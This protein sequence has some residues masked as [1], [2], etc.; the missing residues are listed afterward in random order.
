MG[1]RGPLLLLLALGSALAQAPGDGGFRLM[2]PPGLTRLQLPQTTVPPVRSAPRPHLPTS[3]Q[4]VVE[5]TDR[6]AEASDRAI[7]ARLSAEAREALR[8]P[9]G[10]LL[11]AELGAFMAQAGRAHPDFTQ[12]LLDASMDYWLPKPFHRGGSVEGTGRSGLSVATGGSLGARD[13]S[14]RGLLGR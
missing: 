11:G 13:A 8:F 3:G 12:A 7:Q 5:V 1:C 14:R 2:P 4:A 10:S 6:D 9:P